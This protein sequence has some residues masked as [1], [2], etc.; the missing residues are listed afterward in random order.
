MPHLTRLSL[1][2][3][4]IGDEGVE[5]IG[6]SQIASQLRV[7]ELSSNGIGVDGIRSL[8]RA[9]RFQMLEYLGLGYDGYNQSGIGDAMVT[10]LTTGR[11]S[12]LRHLRLFSLGLTTVA[13]ESLAAW[14]GA[15]SLRHLQLHGD[16]TI[17]VEGIR[18]LAASPYLR[19]LETIDLF[20]WA[21]QRNEIAGI[22][23]DWLGTAEPMPHFT[24]G[25]RGTRTRDA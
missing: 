11:F 1:D 17:R 15:P 14:S 6:R 13:A 9:G 5:L 21:A 19:E 12:R 25:L 10:A 4:K 7:L 8:A 3:G 22:L 24:H 2:S 16:V 23:T 20:P 18:A